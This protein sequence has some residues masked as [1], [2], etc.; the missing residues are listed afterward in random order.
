[1]PRPCAAS[2]AQPRVDFAL[3]ADI[4][5]ARRLVEQQQPRIAEDLL[6]QHDLLLIA[7]RQRAD[8]DVGIASA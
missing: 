2:C 6:G 3:G 5:A 7:A 1:M 4:D 8:G